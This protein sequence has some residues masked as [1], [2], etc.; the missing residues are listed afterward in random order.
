VAPGRRSP[1]PPTRSA[2]PLT[3]GRRRPR[4]PGGTLT[5]AQRRARLALAL[6]AL[7]LV[8][9]VIV[10]GIAGGSHPSLPRPPAPTVVN[11]V[12]S[13]DPFAYSS[14]DA[15]DFVARATAGNAHVLFVKSPG[16][17]LA[18]AARVAAYRP[19]INRAVAGTSLD[20]NLVEGLVFVESAGRPDAIAGTD[21][22]DAAGLTQIL[23][24]TGQSMLGMHI[25]LA[26]SRKLTAQIDAVENGARGRLGPL[27]ARRAAADPRFD[28]SEALAAT[29]RY[30]ETAR[31]QFGREDL[32]IESYH[33]GIGNLHQVLDD[34]DGGRPVPYAQ[35]YFDSAPTR[36]PAA[37]RLLAGFGDDSELY[38]W[39][40]LGAVAIMHLYRTDRA[41]LKRLD[42]FQLA[43]DAGGSVLHP[44]VAPYADPAAVAAAYQRHALIPLPRN[45]AALGLDVLPSMGQGAAQVGA[46]P[47]LYRGLRPAALRMLIDLVD[48]VRSLSRSRAPLQIASTVQDERFQ[49]RQVGFVEPNLAT[50]WAFAIER[51]YVSGAQANAFQAVLDRLQSLNLIAWAREPS[52][53]EVTV[54]SDAAAWLARR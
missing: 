21:P 27:L 36:H 48:E 5:I 41:A 31:S 50:G 45:A 25:N 11:D 20:P 47:A 12:R 18:T 34:Y 2:A 52:T 40:V 39:R 54:A 42:G 9:A 17:A 35:V 3:G 33:M 1:R 28:P 53:I 29:V 44:R 16:G 7:I 38:Y 8:V 46:P 23:A 14:A 10:S 26:R 51:N 24:A 6:A 37:Y 32:A 15:A 22:A 19:L 4:R 30:L 13:G 49:R 43:D